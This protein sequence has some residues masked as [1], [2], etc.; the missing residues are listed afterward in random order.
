MLAMFSSSSRS[1]ISICTE[2]TVWRAKAVLEGIQVQRIL[3]GRYCSTLFAS[4]RPGIPNPLLN[5]HGVGWFDLSGPCKDCRDAQDTQVVLR[6]GSSRHDPLPRGSVPSAAD[7]SCNWQALQPIGPERPT[8]GQA[9][10]H[11]WSVRGNSLCI[12]QLKKP[13]SVHRG[14]VWRAATSNAKFSLQRILCTVIWPWKQ[15][16]ALKRQSGGPKQCLKAFRCKGS[17]VEDVVPHFLLAKGPECPIHSWT[18]MTTHPHHHLSMF[19]GPKLILDDASHL[20]LY[21]ETIPKL[22]ILH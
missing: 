12:C 13:S 2:K 21:T 7:W 9:R 14:T 19:F 22:S 6:S 1:S 17:C 11:P 4:K 5:R 15:S 20:S 10:Q 3:C 18:A 8:Q 16:A